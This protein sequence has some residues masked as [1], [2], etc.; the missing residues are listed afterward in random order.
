MKLLYITTRISGAG[1]MQR[2]LSVKTAA[3]AA[4]GHEVSILITNADDELVYYRFSAAVQLHTIT[5]DRRIPNYFFSYKK[6]LNEAVAR[7][8]PD[9]V[10]M[11]DNGL[12]GFL[13]PFILN[14]KY[15]VVY[16]RHGSKYIQ[17]KPVK[18]TLVNALK[19]F[20]IHKIMDA[21]S[22]RFDRFVVLTQAGRKEWTRDNIDVIPNPLW[23]ETNEPAA[24]TNKIAIGVGRHTYE[25]GYDRMFA[26]W[27]MVIDDYPGWILKIY[28]DDNPECDLKALA[29]KIGV[30]DA[31]QFLPPQ[32]DIAKAYKEASV[33]LMAS[34][35]EGFGMVLLEA[36]A[37]GVPCVA[38]N[39]PAGPA[40]IITDAENGFL[41][42][43]GNIDA[44]AG[45]VRLLLE[46][47]AL[48]KDLGLMARKSSRRFALDTIMEKWEALFNSLRR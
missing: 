6:L 28:G 9:A 42:E 13:L 14:K 21:G 45:K 5:P 38:F 44:Y 2:V 25:K 10:I 39:C 27:K 31:V 41:I 29:V 36:M 34:R 32:E 20:G 16:E 8:N 46:N 17:E 43:D 1:G 47:E 30:A 18:K 35:S 4:K 11:V 15:P 22:K 33:C 19:S 7:I 3:L 48:R 23:F 40:E 24:L 12:K 37:C 26:A